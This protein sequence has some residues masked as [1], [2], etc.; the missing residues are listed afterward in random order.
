M[1]TSLFGLICLVCFYVIIL[2]FGLWMSRIKDILQSDNAD[3]DLLLAG[4]DLGFVVGLCSLVATEVGGA[5]VN[6]SAQEVYNRGIWKMSFKI[7]INNFYHHNRSVVVFSSNRLQSEY[8]SQ[9]IFL[10]G[11][12]AISSLCHTNWFITRYLWKCIGWT[13]LS[14][15]MSWRYMLDSCCAYSTWYVLTFINIDRI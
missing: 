7:Q 9:C 3:L 2:G 12:I 4:R 6:G 13:H 5:F 11:Q 8:D 14:A 15:F 10:C 1:D